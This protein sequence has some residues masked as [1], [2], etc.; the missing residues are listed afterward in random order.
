MKSADKT[1]LFFGSGNVLN[2]NYGGITACF[3]S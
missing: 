1:K 2:C 3:A